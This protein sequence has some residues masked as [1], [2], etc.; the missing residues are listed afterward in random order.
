HLVTRDMVSQMKRG[1]VIVDVAV[2]QGGC[3]ETTHATTH[4]NPVYEVDDVIHYCVANMP[5]AVPRTSTFALTNATLP[6][7]LTLARQGLRDAVL[8]S[9]MLR[10]GVNVYKGEIVC[11][12]VA[13]GQG[14]ASRELGELLN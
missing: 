3:V 7:V 11:R 10:Q 9:P 1:S 6:H 4:S 5:A 12:A 13:E 8:S 2:D 14:L